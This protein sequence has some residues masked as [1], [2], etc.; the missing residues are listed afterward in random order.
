MNEY[1]YIY[2]Y[3]YICVSM[4]VCMYVGMHVYKG[5]FI[6]L[7]QVSLKKRTFLIKQITLRNNGTELGETAIPLS[8]SFGSRLV[9]HIPTRSPCLALFTDVRNIC[10]DLT[11]RVICKYG[12][13]ISFPGWI[14]PLNTVPV[15]TV[16][17][18]FMAKQ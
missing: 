14:H 7:L 4:Y 5:T 13:S 6:P 17:C 1:I 11:F 2:I 18:P 9:T 3:T 12:S 16:P 15:S 10:I 8:I